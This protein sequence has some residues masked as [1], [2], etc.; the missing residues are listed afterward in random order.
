MPK[1]DYKELIKELKLELCL[2]IS[3]QMG[4][5]KVEEYDRRLRLTLFMDPDIQA[6]FKPEKVPNREQETWID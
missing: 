4:I 1:E 3:A 2:A 6:R 5:S